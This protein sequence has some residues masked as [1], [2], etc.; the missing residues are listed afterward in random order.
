M[1]GDLELTRAGEW[2]MAPGWPGPESGPWPPG[3]TRAG[4]W[5]VAPAFEVTSPGVAARRSVCGKPT[6]TG[7]CWR[8]HS[9][10]SPSPH[11]PRMHLVPV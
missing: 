7:G 9:V 5:A 2:A 3:L 1:A 8:E 11:S 6:D 10:T 4:E